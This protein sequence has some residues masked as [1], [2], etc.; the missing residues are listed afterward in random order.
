MKEKQWRCMQCGKL[1]GMLRSERLHLRFSR[2]HEYLVG[3][4][5]TG[6]CRNCGTL[7]ELRDSKM[8]PP[9]AAAADP[10]FE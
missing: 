1:L 9:A 7:N 3:F 2:G 8:Q 10:Q 5:V 6:V 4:P